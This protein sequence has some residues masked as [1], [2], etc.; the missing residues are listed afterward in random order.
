[1]IEKVILQEK[2]ISDYE[3]FIETDLLAE[4]NELAGK[5]QGKK[6]VHINATSKLGGGGVAEILHSL[7][8]MMINLGIDASWYTIT[9]PPEFFGVTNKIHNAIQG[10]EIGLTEEDKK[11]YI[12]HS[13][14]MAQEIE[15]LKADLFIIHDPQP[16]LAATFSNRIKPAISR[17]HI[18]LSQPNREVWNFLFPYFKPYEKVILSVHDFI[19]GNF[20]EKNIVISP[21]A[22]DP[23]SPK[24]IVFGKEAAK[25]IIESLGI[26]SS[27]PIV[28]Q[29]SRL[30][31]FKDP[32]GVIKAFYIAK[33]T[34]PN[35]QLILLAQN[36]ASDN[37][38]SGEIHEKIKKYTDGDHDIFLFYD[39]DLPYDN[40]T[41]V[42]AIQS[43]SDI[44]IQKSLKEG[45]GLT[46]TEAMWK[47]KAVIAGRVGG[48]KIQIKDGFNGFLVSTV[49]HCAA[50]IVELI[51]NP[52]MKKD[53][54]KNARYSVRKNFL[55]PRL[56]R[57]H[58]KLYCEIKKTR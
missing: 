26:N 28:S 30:D 58:L 19:N 32:I 14:E 8:P 3:D 29:I 18:D 13:K 5:L 15:R 17:I 45:F 39:Q 40:D 34:I 11:L 31:K 27:K 49:E 2:N 22:I 6:I 23:L 25:R 43:I 16:L 38:L 10:S 50:R 33:K 56:L 24:N 36:I 41:L 47:N 35:L 20:D 52:E 55:M 54:E 53:I 1:M 48:I 51:K 9:P 57:D 7:I 42:N 37:P 12:K 46:V 4:I 44:V 21:P